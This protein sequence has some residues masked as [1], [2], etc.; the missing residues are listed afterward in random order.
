MAYVKVDPAYHFWAGVSIPSAFIRPY[1]WPTHVGYRYNLKGLISVQKWTITWEE[2]DK[3]VISSGAQMCQLH[4]NKQTKHHDTNL[5][6][7]FIERIYHTVNWYVTGEVH[8]Q[9]NFSVFCNQPY[10]KS[11]KN[12]LRVYECACIYICVSLCMH[13]SLYKKFLFEIQLQTYRNFTETWTYKEMEAIH[14][15]FILFFKIF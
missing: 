1:T 2:Q 9:V 14:L 10:R 6:F 15:I 12:S 5:L 8:I 13:V 4:T 7:T 3:K 11:S